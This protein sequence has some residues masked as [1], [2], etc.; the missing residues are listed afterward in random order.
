MASQ[1]VLRLFFSQNIQ[2]ERKKV[3]HVTAPVCETEEEERNKSVA[4]V[5]YYCTFINKEKQ[6]SYW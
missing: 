1:K 6:S 5:E 4:Q 3:K 2:I